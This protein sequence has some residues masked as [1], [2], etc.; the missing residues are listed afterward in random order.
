VS[1]AIGKPE[2]T[3]T[4]RVVAEHLLIAMVV[5]IIAHFVGDFIG[6]VFV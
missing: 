3:S 6:T 2:K 5:I 4:W 1:Y